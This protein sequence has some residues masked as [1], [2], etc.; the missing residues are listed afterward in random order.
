MRLANRLTHRSQFVIW[1][2][3]H[4]TL[5]RILLIVVVASAEIP[6]RAAIAQDAPAIERWDRAVCLQTE[7]RQADGKPAYSSAFVVVDAD[8]LFLVTAAHAAD[9]THMMS[10][11]VYRAADG[12]SK[13][14]VLGG[15]F[16]K[17]GNPWVGFENSDVAV[18]L[19]DAQPAVRGNVD[20]LRALAIPLAS[21]RQ[22]AP[23]R[24]TPIEITGFPIAL[25]LIPPISPLA[26]NG[27]LASRELLAD[28]KWGQE[29]VL[30]AVPTVGA[31]TSGGPVFETCDDPAEVNVIGLYSGLVYDSSGTKLSK[32]VPA[33]I[34]R[35][36]IQRFSQSSPASD[37]KSK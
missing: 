32:L 4:M 21:L 16:T 31:G 30:Y 24:T 12:E 27:H 37:E 34:V 29:P 17:N 9:E 28:A 18:A 22:D 15:L 20:D 5:A 33:R 13:W 23:R 8:R 3:P 7:K 26:M 25:G 10:R 2:A 35:A 1:I 36:A 6:V 11:V 14:V 19:I